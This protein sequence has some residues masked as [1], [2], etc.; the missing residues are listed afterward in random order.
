MDRVKYVTTSKA[1]AGRSRT[2]T[3]LRLTFL[4]RL[5]FR[6][7]RNHFTFSG[8]DNRTRTYDPVINSRQ[9]KTMQITIIID[10][11][12]FYKQSETRFRD[13]SQR[14]KR[15]LTNYEQSLYY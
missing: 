5:T 11:I 10:E 7:H 4:G 9:A 15:D 12:G 1:K 2:Q 13:K 8:S 3:A 6:N 14:F